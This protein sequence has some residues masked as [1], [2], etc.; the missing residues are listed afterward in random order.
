ML[1]C[2]FPHSPFGNALTVPTAI[3][4]M[5]SEE[6][7]PDIITRLMEETRQ[8]GFEPFHVRRTSTG[9]IYNRYGTQPSFHFPLKKEKLPARAGTI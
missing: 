4:I 3:E 7:K 1:P 5:G 2:S 9:Y 6:T 8:H